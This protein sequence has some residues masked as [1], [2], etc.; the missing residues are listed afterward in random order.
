M[1][2][3]FRPSPQ[4]ACP[5]RPR[6]GGCP[7]VDDSRTGSSSPRRHRWQTSLRRFRSTGLAPDT[8]A[9]ASTAAHTPTPRR[10]PAI[11]LRRSV[12]LNG[13][14]CGVGSR[15]IDA[16][17]RHF[18]VHLGC[19]SERVSNHA[20]RRPHGE[21][22]KPE[23]AGL[24]RRIARFFGPGQGEDRFGTAGT[25]NSRIEG[26]LMAG[27]LRSQGIKAVVSADDE[28]ALN[29]VLQPGRVRVLVPNSQ[30]GKAKRLIDE[31]K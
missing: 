19:H 8:A 10:T 5:D 25:A 29:P 18:L 26:E 20:H 22:A 4:A 17:E 24:L 3:T 21:V 2:P 7:P 23:S 28:G 1:R 27:Y 9:T 12:V 6:D 13:S 31:T 15:R 11:V 30:H 14:T 16:R